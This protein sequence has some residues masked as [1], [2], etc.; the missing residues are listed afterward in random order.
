VACEQAKDPMKMTSGN[1][2]FLYALTVGVF[3]LID[4]LWLGVVAKGFYQRYMGSLMRENVNWVAAVLFYLI[5]IGGIQVFVLLPAIQADTG[6]LKTT[7]MG[8][9]LG[10]FAYSTFDLTSLALLKNWSITVV[11]VDIIWGILLTGS[12]AGVV[13]WLFRSIV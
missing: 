13:L 4:L 10:F 5:Y 9:L 1:I 7:I 8:G 12:T 2:L 6:V 3:F 11:V